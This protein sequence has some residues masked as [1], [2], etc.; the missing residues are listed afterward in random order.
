MDAE[1]K[2][3]VIDD[4]EIVRELLAEVLSNSGF[5]VMTAESGHI[6]LDYFRQPDCRYD[7][8]IVDMSMPDMNGMEVCRELRKIAPVQKIM[9]TTGSYPNAEEI[10]EL[11]QNGIEH[12]VKKPFNLN[13]L[14]RLVRSELGCS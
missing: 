12:I 5:Q 7:L 9:I 2:I 6:G 3:F 4:E 13:E 14:I 1:K 10:A 8:V 11:K